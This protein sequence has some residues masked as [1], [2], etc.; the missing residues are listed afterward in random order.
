MTTRIVQLLDTDTDSD[1][2]FQ[3]EFDF[4]VLLPRPWHNWTLTDT[5]T[6]PDTDPDSAF[7]SEFAVAASS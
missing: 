6:D 7:Q 5:D 2:V 3:S 4:A 1:S